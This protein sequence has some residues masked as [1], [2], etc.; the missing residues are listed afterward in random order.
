[1]LFSIC[2]NFIIGW[3][4]RKGLTMLWSIDQLVVTWLIDWNRLLHLK[5]Y[6]QPEMNFT[7]PERS[8]LRATRSTIADREISIQSRVTNVYRLN[9]IKKLLS[10]GIIPIW[11]QEILRW[12]A[13]RVSN[14]RDPVNQNRDSALVQRR[15]QNLYFEL[16]VLFNYYNYFSVSSSGLKQ[17]DVSKAKLFLK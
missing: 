17:S 13:E 5:F 2:L 16:L 6:S 8:V 9:R 10:D 14:R 11:V 4:V 1:M 15:M 7:P 3:K 12:Y